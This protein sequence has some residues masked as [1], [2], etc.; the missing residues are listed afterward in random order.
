MEKEQRL[1]TSLWESVILVSKQLLG[2]SDQISFWLGSLE[3][4]RVGGE[5]YTEYS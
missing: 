5:N 4:T 1:S 3:L 2:G